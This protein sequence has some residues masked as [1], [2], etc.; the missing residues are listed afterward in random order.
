MKAYPFEQEARHFSSGVNSPGE[1]RGISG[2]VGIAADEIRTGLLEELEAR[3][4]GPTCLFVD[5]GAF[6]EVEFTVAGPV[7]AEEISHLDWL[8]RF[9]TYKRMAAAFRTRC[10]LV[11]PDRVGDQSVTLERLERYAGRVRELAE[12]YRANVIVPVQKGARS[13][14]EF[15][16]ACVDVL[17]LPL[18][19]RVGDPMRPIAGIPMKKDATTIGELREFAATMPAG[20]RFHLLG[21][22]PTSKGYAA[23]VNAIR[24]ACPEASITTDSNTIRR[25]VGRT[26]GVG[27]GPRAL[28]KAQDRAR[29]AGLEGHD[30]KAAA[31]AEVGHAAHRAEVLRAYELGWFDE[32]L[33]GFRPGLD[34]ELETEAA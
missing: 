15:W 13:M 4:G 34:L 32:E 30:V 18:V 1:V 33:E 23:A 20:S 21:L 12:T 11:A 3:A 24:Q 14:A 7:V 26:N 19:D 28:T 16:R 10:Y 25:L 27:K 8:L 29:S 2:W 5:S 31:L 22:G 17:D 9:A 6:S